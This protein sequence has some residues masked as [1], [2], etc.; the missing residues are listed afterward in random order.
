[1]E[2]YIDCLHMPTCRG[3]RKLHLF[4]LKEYC[5]P[6]SV[7]MWSAA[8]VYGHSI[9]EFSGLNPAGDMG[10]FLL[11]LYCVGR[12]LYYGPITARGESYRVCVSLCVI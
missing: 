5:L 1:M 9:A 3:Y 7:A 6:I 4:R 12:S 8:Y 11:C 10:V 2:L